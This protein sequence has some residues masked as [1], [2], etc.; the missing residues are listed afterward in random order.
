VPEVSVKRTELALFQIIW[1]KLQK[2]CLFNTEVSI[3]FNSMVIFLGFRATG[4]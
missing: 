4:C 2:N 1:R 3:D